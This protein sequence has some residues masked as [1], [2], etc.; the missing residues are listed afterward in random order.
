M[1]LIKS[2]DIKSKFLSFFEENNHLKISDSSIIPKNDPTLLF[3]N[4][5]MAP[6]KRFFT[7]E[8][9]PKSKR[10]CNIQPCIRTI[11]IDQVGDKHHL[12]SFQ[13]LGSWSIGDYFKEDAIKLAYKFLTEYIKIPKEKL[14]VTIFGGDSELG[15]EQDN[16]AKNCW[17]SVGVPEDHIVACPKEDNF[18][19]PTSETGPCGP[20]TEVFFDT[21]DEAGTKYIPGQHFDTQKRYIEIWNAGVFMQFNKNQDGSYSKLK[22]KSVDTGAGLE[23]L[24]MV[25]N[26]LETVYDTD[27]LKPIKDQITSQLG[28]SDSIPQREILIMTDHLRTACLI[29]SE[30][31]K[32]SN[33]GRGYIPRKLIRKCI[34]ITTKSKIFDFDF[35]KILEF[36]INTYKHMF[37][38]FEINQNYILETFQKEYEQFSKVITVGLEKLDLIKQN[39]QNNHLTN[40]FQINSEE[41]FELVTT[42]GLPF[43]IIK[44]YSQENNLS[45]DEIGYKQK[46][47]EH[48]N[49]SRNLQNSK[50]NI[51]NLD[52]KFLNQIS[53]TVFEGYT[54]L[55]TTSKIL[56]LIDKDNLPINKAAFDNSI[57]IILENTVFYAESGGQ[58]SDIGLI[59]SD[60]FKFEVTDVQKTSSGVYIHFGKILSGE[61][62]FELN[63]QSNNCTNKV[64]V[65]VDSDSRQALANNH[66]AVHLLHSALRN[67]YGQE[68]HQAGS[69]VEKDKLRFDFNCEQ[70]I[71]SENV[72][73]IEQLVNKYIRE[74]ADVSTEIKSLDDAVKDGAMALFEDKY[75][76][77]VRVVSI[78][79]KNNTLENNNLENKYISQELCGGTHTPQTGNIGLFVILSAEGIGKGMKRISALT[80]Q[81]AI[82]YIQEQ[83]NLIKNVS[84]KLSVKP[85]KILDKISSLQSNK[86]SSKNKVSS[87]TSPDQLSYQTYE[88]SSQQKIALVCHD[89]F[90][91]SLKDSAMALSD[92]LQAPVIYLGGENQKQILIACTKNISDKFPANNLLNQILTAIGEGKGG[93]SS[94]MA[95]GGGITVSFDKFKD[96]FKKVLK[97]YK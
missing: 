35:K 9:T 72:F 97:K 80:G 40:D 27:L 7:G 54:A 3:I 2:L 60:N 21:E 39:S 41:I 47:E 86:N 63:D 83:S 94:R 78:K 1:N 48:K 59:Y 56:N 51:K 8:E 55:K 92:K 37:K 73:K 53:P 87:N 71:D 65:E 62:N 30:K 77:E 33:E 93:G 44:D 18:W 57:G 20:C 31:V 67:I 85:D 19:G 38:N 81:E 76:Q 49:I 42:F 12:T 17:I 64:F 90:D 32:P 36:I 74:N 88:V 89:E 25:L 10:L 26:N 50:N 11:D 58:C 15:L 95:S 84:Q 6:L 34:L 45:I 4:S 22:F 29:L 91:K 82:K 46:L 66:T 79:H 24:A 96:K 68:L 28:N 5:G 69:K 14:Y 16:E 43:D 13:M 23:R 61:I 52:L 75:S 70:K